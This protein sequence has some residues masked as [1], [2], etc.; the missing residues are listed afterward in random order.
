MDMT[1]LKRANRRVLGAA[2]VSAALLVPLGVFGAPALA[3]SAA[4]ASQYQYG[5]SSQYQYKITICHHT[6]SGK[7]GMHTI[8]ISIKAWKA[9]QRHGDTFG[10]CV[11][12]TAPTA[13]TTGH[14]NNGKGHG[15]DSHGGSSTIHGKSGSS[16]G[17]NGNGSGGGKGHDK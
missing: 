12:V 3:R 13:P 17:K 7:H 15:D 6:H 11:P 8:R 5:G 14:G 4:S 2:A 1:F 9:H 10:A 16:H